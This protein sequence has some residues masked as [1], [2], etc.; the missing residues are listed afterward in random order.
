LVAELHCPVAFWRPCVV[1]EAKG[2]IKVLCVSANSASPAVSCEVCFCTSVDLG[3][4]DEHRQEELA[5]CVTLGIV[6]WAEPV[7][8]GEQCTS[9]AFLGACVV[10]GLGQ[11]VRVKHTHLVRTKH[12]MQPTAIQAVIIKN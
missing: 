6:E 4:V 7:P 12:E 8:E 9:G 5:A 2:G 3:V 1:E 10:V 11:R